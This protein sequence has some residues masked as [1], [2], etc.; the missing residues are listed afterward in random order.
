MRASLAVSAADRISHTAIVVAGSLCGVLVFF[1]AVPLALSSPYPSPK[2]GD[3]VIHRSDR[4]VASPITLPLGSELPSSLDRDARTMPEPFSWN[5]VSLPV[6]DGPSLFTPAEKD[7]A[8][9]GSDVTFS[10]ASVS[11]TEVKLD[12]KPA[13]TPLVPV[14]R[15]NAG[16]IEEV[17]DY[18]WEVYQR[19]PVKKDGAG[20]F[21]WKDPAAAKRMGMSMQI[22]T[23][24]GMDADFR[25]QLY[26]AGHAMDDAGIRWSMLSAFR[27]DYRQSIASGLAAGA[28]NSMHGGKA[29]VGGYG[30]GQAIDITNTEGD[31][32]TVYRWIDRNG[33]KYGLYR[34]MPGYDPGHIQPRDA[35]H[36]IAGTFRA[37]RVRLAEEE[38]KAAG[39]K[40]AA[41]TDA[42]AKSEAK[43]Q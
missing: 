25:E 4:H 14:K 36:K 22:Y 9:S 39:A 6:Y 23:I 41:A 28:S 21:T 34:P 2:E 7:T 42:G 30:H 35:W 40:T 3:W 11:S 10:L 15:S 5:F 1:V 27:D 43:A 20:D 12:P 37:N 24:G 16:T 17:N 32:N 33:A 31:D 38:Q 18:L 26:H 13:P 29:R 19:A 8:D